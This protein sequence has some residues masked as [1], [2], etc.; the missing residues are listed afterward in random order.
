MGLRELEAAIL[1]EAREVT[2]NKKLRQ[3]DIMEWTTGD[4]RPRDDEAVYRLPVV[5]VNIA[6]KKP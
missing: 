2:G 3:K 5:G 1:K 6:V 4:I